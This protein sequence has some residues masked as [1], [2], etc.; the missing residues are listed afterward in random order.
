MYH[1][2]VF[3]LNGE[4]AFLRYKT[5]PVD[6]SGMKSVNPHS[7]LNKSLSVE[8]IPFVIKFCR[9]HAQ[10]IGIISGIEF[11]GYADNVIGVYYVGQFL[12]IF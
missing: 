6:A 7:L 12:H 3:L 4:S 5:R 2:K 10:E 11:C 1:R 9:A 8:Q